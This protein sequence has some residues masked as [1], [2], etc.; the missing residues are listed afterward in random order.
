MGMARK[1]S[2]GV[3][4]SLVKLKGKPRYLWR[5]IDAA[6][7][8]LDVYATETRTDQ[9]EQAATRFLKQALKRR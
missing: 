6:G 8:V 9:D 4:V 3:E 1:P 5:A 7:E 2:W